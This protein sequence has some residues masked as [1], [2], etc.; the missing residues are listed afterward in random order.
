MTLLSVIAGPRVARSARTRSP[1]P[2]ATP[3]PCAPV[4]DPRHPLRRP[5]SPALAAVTRPRG[6][7]RPGRLRQEDGR[8]PRS[9]HA[10]LAGENVDFEGEHLAKG[11]TINPRPK[12]QLMPLWLGG[13]SKPAIRRT[14]YA[15]ATAGSPCSRRRKKP[16]S[17]SPTSRASARR[18]ADRSRTITT[19]TSS[20]GSATAARPSAPA[21]PE[22]PTP[23]RRGDAQPHPACRRSAM[24]RRS[25]SAFASSAITASRSSSRSR[26]RRR[27][28]T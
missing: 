4:R 16:A 5:V 6:D 15:M 22:S 25:W 23:R 11:A 3:S 21:K 28:M 13:S 7:R 18:S 20:S 10:P 12:Q 19:P 27:R 1:C 8:G 14:G 26:W 2:S 17:P 9:H 24:P